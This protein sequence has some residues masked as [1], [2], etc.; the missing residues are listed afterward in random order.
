VS[1]APVFI[2]EGE[3]NWAGGHVGGVILI[4]DLEVSPGVRSE[5]MR[6]AQL[7]EQIHVAQH[8]FGAL[9]WSEP[10]GRRLLKRVPGGTA[11][12]PHLDLGLDLPL[13]GALMLLLEYEHR[14]WEWEAH[15]LRRP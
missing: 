6:R 8:D 15:F 2:H 7:H 5:Q 13:W 1:G 14:P 12:S 11:I 10:A 9:V 3:P 4:R